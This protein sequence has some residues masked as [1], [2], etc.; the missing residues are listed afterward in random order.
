MTKKKLFKILLCVVLLVIAIDVGLNWGMHWYVSRFDFPGDYRK[1]EYM[2]KHVDA[3]ILLLGASTCMNSINPE[4]LE[5]DLGKSAFNGGVNDQRLEFMDVMTDA[6]FSYAPPELLILVLRPD[7]LSR[8]GV[9]RLALMNIYYHC[10]HAKLD[11]YLDEG[12]L[13]QRILLGSALYRF[14]T[15]WWRILLYHFK[16]FGELDHGGFVGK[17]VPKL[18]PKHLDV[19]AGNTVSP[20][21]PR[22]LQCLENILATCRKTGTRLWIVIPPEYF[23]HNGKD[24]DGLSHIRDFCTRNEIPFTD[25]SKNPDYVD[26]P[27]Y[28]FDNHHLNVNGAELYSRRISK[29]LQEDKL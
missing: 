25:D 3:Q 19:P 21:I 7:D 9:G 6:I 12:K 20:V 5:K 18:P 11:D 16:S 8:S 10:G 22:K 26:H 23:R 15:H 17:P 28:F 13:K 2:F 24:H 29:L 1:F 14:N 4:I 27:E